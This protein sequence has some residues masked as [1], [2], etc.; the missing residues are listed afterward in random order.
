[1]PDFVLTGPLVAAAPSTDLARLRAELRAAWAVAGHVLAEA[2]AA[3]WS[4]RRPRQ[5][6]RAPWGLA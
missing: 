2:A 4:E 6:G 5:V 1:M 3:Q